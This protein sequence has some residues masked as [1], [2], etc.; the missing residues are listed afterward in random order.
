MSALLNWLETGDVVLFAASGV[1]RDSDSAPNSAA[2]SS[3]GPIREVERST[4]RLVW[5]IEDDAFAR[6]VVHCVCRWHSVVS[7]S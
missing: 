1:V 2:F 5:F 6:Y 4:A 3:S 7:Y